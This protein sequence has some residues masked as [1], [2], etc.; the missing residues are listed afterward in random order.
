MED[1]LRPDKM[2]MVDAHWQPAR[3]RAIQAGTPPCG[4]VFR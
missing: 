4:L 2:R 1:S 3:A